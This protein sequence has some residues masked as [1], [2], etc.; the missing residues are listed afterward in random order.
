MSPEGVFKMY[1]LGEGIA[2]ST[3]LKDASEIRI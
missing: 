3:G 1:D 2:G